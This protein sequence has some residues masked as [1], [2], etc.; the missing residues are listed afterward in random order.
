[1][2]YRGAPLAWVRHSL[3]KYVSQYGWLV[4]EILVRIPKDINPQARPRLY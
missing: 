3:G 2:E 1:M 4:I